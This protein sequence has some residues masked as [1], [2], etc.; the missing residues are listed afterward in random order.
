MQLQNK[1][2]FMSAVF[3]NLI[4]Q[5][6]VAYQ[7]AKTVVEN[8]QYSDFMARN[9]L[10]NLLL[11]LGLFLTLVFV[12]M[13]LPVKF[14]IFTLIS[15]LIGAYISPQADAKESLLE[16]VG[17]FIALFVLGLL[18]VQFGLDLRPMGIF[19]FLALL[20]LLVSRLFSPGKKKYAKI[21]SL[22]FALFVVYDTNN[23]LQKN[24]GGDFINASMDYFLDILNLFQY[25]TEE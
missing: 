3:A 11:L 20:A 4:F 7:S 24:Y 2:T 9:A 6:L 10:L 23:I 14:M 8:P 25:N 12:K 15:A 13:S 18:S 16:V 21:G 17:I 1:K 22:I 19:L 5:G